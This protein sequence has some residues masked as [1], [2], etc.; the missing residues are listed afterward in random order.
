MQGTMKTAVMT[1]LREISFV[2][3]PIPKPGPDEALIR[4]E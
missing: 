1:R 2:E 4:L 3:R